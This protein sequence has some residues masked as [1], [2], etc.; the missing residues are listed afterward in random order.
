MSPISFPAPIRQLILNE[1]VLIR[2]VER[3][4]IF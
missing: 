3:K 2:V 1:M 4:I